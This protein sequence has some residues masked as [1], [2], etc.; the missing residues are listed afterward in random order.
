MKN[1]KS[2]ILT[3]RINALRLDL[4]K[5]RVFTTADR[6]VLVVHDCTST[7]RLNLSQV[8]GKTRNSRDQDDD[9]ELSS[10]FTSSDTSFDNRASNNIMNRRLVFSSSGDWYYVSMTFSSGVYA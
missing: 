7:G 10:L 4:P 9:S 1:E 2:G 5:D 8:T 3:C 6:L